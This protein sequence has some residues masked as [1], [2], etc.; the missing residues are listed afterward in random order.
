MKRTARGFPIYSE[1]T[2]SYGSRIRVQKSSAALIDAV[3]IFCDKHDGT[4]EFT[5]HLTVAQAKRMIR[6]LQK[7]VDEV[8][9]NA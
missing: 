5:P 1:F 9:S 4:G 6:G 3:W 2:D 7:F 8:Q